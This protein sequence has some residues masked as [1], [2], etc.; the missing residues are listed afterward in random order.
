SAE[1]LPA[2]ECTM[3]PRGRMSFSHERRSGQTGSGAQLIQTTATPGKHTLTES[4]PPVQR[5]QP[6][7][8]H[9]TQS[10]GEVQSIAARGASGS[11]PLP[12]VDRIQRAF[13]PHDVSGVRA[14]VGG[15]ATAACEQ[16]GAESYAQGNSVAFKQSPSL[17]LA[18]H[19]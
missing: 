8:D 18:A 9:G 10:P 14:T 11:A 7:G 15:T 5:Y 13:G 17:W 16:M 2:K 1:A 6:A 4:L 3:P 12:H 19:E